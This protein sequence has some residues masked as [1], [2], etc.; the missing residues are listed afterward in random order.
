MPHACDAFA[1]CLHSR[2]VNPSP[3]ILRLLS[4]IWR[5]VLDPTESCCASPPAVAVLK[6]K[7]ANK[8]GLF[9]RQES[10]HINNTAG[11]AM[12][13]HT[14]THT[15]SQALYYIMYINLTSLSK[16][17]VTVGVCSMKSE[18]TTFGLL[19]QCSACWTTGVLCKQ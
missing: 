17:S 14:H 4:L 6:H 1:T 11:K 8:S 13:I 18:P 5:G 3:H 15:Q 16:M 10:K 19:V 12:K 7:H 2:V 9:C